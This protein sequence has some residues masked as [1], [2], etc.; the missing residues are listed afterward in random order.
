MQL[1]FEGRVFY[2]RCGAKL[3]AE[4]E[5]GNALAGQKKEHRT[6]PRHSTLSC[7][8]TCKEVL[9]AFR[10]FAASSATIRY[11]VNYR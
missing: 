7:D 9:S 1:L 10:H 5:L 3:R 11:Y 6:R 2:E 8:S 4:F